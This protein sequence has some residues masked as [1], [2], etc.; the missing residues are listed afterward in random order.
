ML[1]GFIKHDHDGE[2]GSSF[3]Y[4]VTLTPGIATFYLI[5]DYIYDHS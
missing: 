2:A 1:N 4:S 3:M 5:R